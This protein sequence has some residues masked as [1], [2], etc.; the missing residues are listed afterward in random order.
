MENIKKILALVFM[1]TILISCNKPTLKEAEVLIK[2]AKYK[3]AIKIIRPLAKKGNDNAQFDLGS[4]YYLGKGVKQDYKKAIKWHTKAAEQGY[5]KS[6]YNLGG[7]YFYGQGV[8]RDYKEAIKWHTKAA[9]QGYPEAQF[10]LGIIYDRGEEDFLMMDPTLTKHQLRVTKNY[11]EAYKWYYLA[12][13]QN[14]RHAEYR[15]DLGKKMTK[16]Q[17]AEAKKLAFEFVAKKEK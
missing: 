14:E 13:S 1:I 2:A 10:S 8:T 17:I 7:I 6:Q 4:M 9:N 5:A 11:V 16:E 12:A 15:D 3:E